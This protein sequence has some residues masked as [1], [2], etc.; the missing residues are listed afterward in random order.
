MSPEF[1]NTETDTVAAGASVRNVAVCCTLT[2]A[3]PDT[4][5]VTW[6]SVPYASALSDR[7]SAF[8]QWKSRADAG[9]V[10][11][12][13][14]TAEIV[15]ES[16]VTTIGVSG[17]TAVAPDGGANDKPAASATRRCAAT[18]RACARSRFA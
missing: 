11:E 6:Y 4:V 18:T 1:G 15:P 5:A 7:H 3:G 14:L 13:T 16:A 9:A 10:V 2:F 8:D 17:A 12:V